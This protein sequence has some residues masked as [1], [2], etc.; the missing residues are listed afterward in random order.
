MSSHRGTCGRGHGG[1]NVRRCA[2]ERR[3]K[4][5]YIS[6]LCCAK[7]A[8]CWHQAK[9]MRGGGGLLNA[10]CTTD[11]CNGAYKGARRG[12]ARCS[13]NVKY[14]RS[15]RMLAPAMKYS[16]TYRHRENQACRFKHDDLWLLLTSAIEARSGIVPTIIMAVTHGK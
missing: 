4:A 1:E 16:A 9:S 2:I 15:P 7:Q 6:I 14:R 12:I 8:I 11:A 10:G 5:S 3:K 13:R